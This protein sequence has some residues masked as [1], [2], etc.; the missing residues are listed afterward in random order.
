VCARRTDAPHERRWY[1]GNPLK[2]FFS[3]LIV[4]IVIVI[5]KY[6]VHDFAE[7]LHGNHEDWD[8]DCD[9]RYRGQW[10]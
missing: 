10:Y 2:S 3:I 6:A 4:I 8:D 5:V 7:Q 1:W 9:N